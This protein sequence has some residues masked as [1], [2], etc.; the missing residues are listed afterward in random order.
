[1]THY[2]PANPLKEA[3]TATGGSFHSDGQVVILKL[4]DQAK[5]LSAGSTVER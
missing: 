2:L 5:S 3:K 1:V 4:G